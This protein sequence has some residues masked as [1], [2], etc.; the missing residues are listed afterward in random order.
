MTHC[1]VLFL[2]RVVYS[3]MTNHAINSRQIVIPR[4]QTR[5]MEACFLIGY[6]SASRDKLQQEAAPLPSAFRPTKVLRHL[7]PRQKPDKIIFGT[8]TSSDL[9]RESARLSRVWTPLLDQNLWMISFPINHTK[10]KL[11]FFQSRLNLLTGEW[12]AQEMSNRLEFCF[13]STIPD[14]H[15]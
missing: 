10:H 9:W 4:G 15:F 13:F 3:K 8:I 6:R 7:T 1:V 11:K 5:P 2:K 14:G 12:P